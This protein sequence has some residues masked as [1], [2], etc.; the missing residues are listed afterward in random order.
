MGGYNLQ[1]E[2]AGFEF[3]RA[4]DGSPASG[5]GYAELAINGESFNRLYVPWLQVPAQG[6]GEHIFTVV[7]LN[8]EGM[9]YQ[10]GGQ[11]VEASVQVVEKAK[12]DQHGGGSGAS[13]DHHG[14]GAGFV[15]LEVGYL[16]VLP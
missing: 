6:P 9:P 3:P 16:E 1:V 4:V 11:P 7:L 15:E 5:P 10:Y 8:D 13:A 14:D 12:P 2:T